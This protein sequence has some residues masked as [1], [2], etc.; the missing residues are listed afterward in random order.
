MDLLF[1][2]KE[3]YEKPLEKVVNLPGLIGQIELSR[4]GKRAS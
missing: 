2:L 3:Y 1:G 4:T